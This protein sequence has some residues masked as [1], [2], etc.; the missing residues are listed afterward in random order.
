VSEP[1]DEPIQVL[2]IH[3]YRNVRQGITEALRATNRNVDISTAERVGQALATLTEHTDCIVCGY[4]LPGTSGLEFLRLIRAEFGDLP[5][6]LISADGNDALASEAVPLDVTDYVRI[7]ALDSDYGR[8]ADSVLRTVTERRR[9]ESEQYEEL[10]TSVDR[11]R[12]LPNAVHQLSAATSTRQIEKL[13]TEIVRDDLSYPIAELF[14]RRDIKG[15]Y[16]FRTD[17]PAMEDATS[18]I[19]DGDSTGTSSLS[20][21]TSSTTDS[22]SRSLDDIPDPIR[23]AAEGAPVDNFVILPLTYRSTVFGALL[24]GTEQRFGETAVTELEALTG[25]AS[26]ARAHRNTERL[27]LADTVSEL[28]FLVRDPRAFPVATSA[29]LD[30]IWTLEAIT[31]SEHDTYCHRFSVENMAADDLRNVCENH[32]TESRG[33]VTIDE[34]DSRC[35][36]EYYTGQSVFTQLLESGAVIRSARAENGQLRLVAETDSETDIRTLIERFT[37]TYPKTE[38]LAKRDRNRTVGSVEGS[39]SLADQLTAKQQSALRAA[40]SEGYYAWPRDT[41]S[42]EV[43]DSLGVTAPTFLNH[44]RKAHQILVANCLEQLPDK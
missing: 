24:V 23:T 11:T 15:V 39:N 27:L 10:S 7:Q 29:E 6:F 31:L 4:Y 30:C 12:A 41:S 18:L 9:I 22:P 19:P 40:Y 26:L 35:T 14:D 43:A 34:F 13:L 37:D 5:F 2:C 21:S 33:T 25:I 3:Q 32:T 44:L 42:E 16:R 28:K 36:V 20:W 8:F 38:L 17:E 1:L